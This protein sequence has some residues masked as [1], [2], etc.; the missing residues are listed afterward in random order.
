M[1]DE[2]I[3][4]SVMGELR[5]T[6]RPEFLNRIDDIIVFHQLSKDDIS[7]IA[8]NMMDTVSK[9]VESLGV[10]LS[11]DD[12]TI[13]FLAQ[14][15]FDPVYGARPLRRAIQSYV[16]DAIAESLLDGS[17]SSGDEAKVYADD[18]KILVKKV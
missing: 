8:S 7:K 5:N 6:F 16:E 11:V 18:D 1:S 15:G 2:R 13:E 4:E 17:I 12:S 14:R 3:R 9:R 10:D